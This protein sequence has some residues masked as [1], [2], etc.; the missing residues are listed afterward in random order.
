MPGPDHSFQEPLD[1]STS[2]LV[3]GRRTPPV[4]PAG[5]GVALSVPNAYFAWA[6]A[7]K[8]LVAAEQAMTDLPPD[9][10]AMLWAGWQARVLLLRAGSDRLLRQASAVRKEQDARDLEKPQ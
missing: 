4:H 9:A 7:H 6:Q 1:D 2:T 10:S 3:A 8:Q 5:E